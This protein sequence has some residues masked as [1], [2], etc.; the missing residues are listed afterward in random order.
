MDAVRLS[1]LRAVLDEAGIACFVFDIAAGATW[2][3][4]FPSR[5]MVSAE[6]AWLARSIIRSAEADLSYDRA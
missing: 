3:G 5:V 6:E 4:A 2:P 1:F